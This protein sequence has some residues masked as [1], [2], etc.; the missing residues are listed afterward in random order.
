MWL[1]LISMKLR[2]ICALF[3]SMPAVGCLHRK[4][5]RDQQSLV[6]KNCSKPSFTQ[7]RRK[8][9]WQLKATIRAESQFFAFLVAQQSSLGL[10]WGTMSPQRLLCMTRSQGTHTCSSLHPKPQA[11][12]LLIIQP[13]KSSNQR[14]QHL[15]SRIIGSIKRRNTFIWV[16]LPDK[17]WLFPM[18]LSNIKI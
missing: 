16:P 13:F 11:P 6:N 3:P 14:L 8:Y 15:I 12:A 18:P 2:K 1:S 7:V 9:L 10:W 17:A 4:P 5:L